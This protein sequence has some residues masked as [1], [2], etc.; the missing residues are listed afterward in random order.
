M[1]QPHLNASGGPLLA[2]AAHWAFLDE[3]LGG[4]CMAQAFK[5]CG[6]SPPK[7]PGRCPRTLLRVLALK[8]SV[9]VP[10]LFFEVE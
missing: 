3:G 1:S 4:S 2:W 8:R 10:I 7:H 5:S 9:A 6:D